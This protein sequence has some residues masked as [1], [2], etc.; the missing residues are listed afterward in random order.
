[1]AST[2][3]PPSLTYD[4][5]LQIIER[6]KTEGITDEERDAFLEVAVGATG[7]TDLP[8]FQQ[9]ISDIAD[10]A[11]KIDA[12]FDQVDSSFTWITTLELIVQY[13]EIINYYAQW[14]GHKDN[15]RSCLRQSFNVADESIDVL[16][17]FDQVYLSQVENIKTEQDRLNAIQA[18]QQFIDEKHDHSDTMSRDFLNLKRDIQ[19]FVEKFGQWVAGKGLIVDAITVA[20]KSMMDSIQK[21]IEEID[22]MIRYVKESLAIA[23]SSLNVSI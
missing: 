18:L 9:I 11:K 17:R 16:Q 20:L 7:R 2:S 10:S 21:E 4:E 8:G 23:G 14:K 22:A 13:P 12:A 19:S 5:V 1:M 15:W 3:A 6:W